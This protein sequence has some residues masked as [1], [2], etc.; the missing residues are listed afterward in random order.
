MTN[1]E[2]REYNRNRQIV[3]IC[4]VTKDYKR[5]IENWTRIL[6]VGPWNVI[7]F[8]EKN[9]KVNFNKVPCSQ[10]FEFIVCNSMIGNIEI[11]VIQPVSDPNPYSKFLEENGE[12]IHHI[13]E[14]IIDHNKLEDFIKNCETE[15]MP[16][17][18]NGSF[19]RDLFY[20]LDGQSTIGS[21]YE[22]G[23]CPGVDLTPYEHYLYPEE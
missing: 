9:A 23:N 13:K 8:S 20:Y 1:E 12:G 4:Y 15:G 18:F 16:L 6:K 5:T 2:L 22:L 10:P 3:Q 11:E 14:K 21:L 7:P 17:I 19:D